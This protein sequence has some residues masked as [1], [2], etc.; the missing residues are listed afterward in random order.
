LIKKNPNNDELDTPTGGL[1]RPTTFI[2]GKQDRLL[3]KMRSPS[4]MK[5]ATNEYQEELKNRAE[6]FISTIKEHK[7]K[8]QRVH[9][10]FMFSSPLLIYFQSKAS[11]DD[12]NKSQ[13]L[14]KIDF[15]REFGE[16][17]SALIETKTKINYYKMC[18]TIDNLTS[19]LL[20]NPKVF[21]F[22]GHG[23]KNTVEAIGTEAALKQGEGDLLVF[24]DKKG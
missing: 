7:L 22:S 20:R 1:F 17:K 11:E 21:H 18:A 14:M 9:L 2:D 13:S 16:I 15:D 23:V 24:E 3:P 4:L 8:E 12:M 10:A 6:A 5:Q 19:I